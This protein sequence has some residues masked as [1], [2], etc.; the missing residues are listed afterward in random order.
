M[1]KVTLTRKQ[2][3]DLVWG[4]SLLALSKKY[5]ISDVGLRKMCKRM[6]IPLPD[7]GHWN[8]HKAGKLIS[9]KPLP[10][11]NGDE[12]VVNIL[13]RLSGTD[14]NNYGESPLK[15]LQKEIENDPNLVLQ[16]PSLLTSPD[17]L[18]I[19]AKKTLLKQKPLSYGNTSGIVY[20]H[21]GELDIKV[22]PCNVERA[23]CFMDTFIKI[24]NARGHKIILSGEITVSINQ[25]KMQFGLREKLNKSFTETNPGSRNQIV[26]PA[27]I[28]VF[29]IKESAYSIK[30]WKDGKLSLEKQL[31][32]I[33]AWIEL[34]STEIKEERLRIDKFWEER[35]KQEEILLEHS[36]RQEKELIDFKK[37]LEKANRWQRVK[38]LRAY[39]KDIHQKAILETNLTP[40]LSNWILWA[41]KKVD[42][43]DPWIELEDELLKGVDKETLLFNKNTLYT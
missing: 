41:N 4:N 30:E 42:W 35:R 39:L 7:A 3:Y 28:L 21:R 37:L 8:K 40:E 18:V 25:E 10:H 1:D 5:C 17:I 27:G 13:L 22:S 43:Y 24:L 32:K 6:D 33:I 20:C 38:L 19:G 9:V 15:R 2:L 23:L 36:R 31:P 34:K 26:H 29:R 11:K 16:V 12:Q 14:H